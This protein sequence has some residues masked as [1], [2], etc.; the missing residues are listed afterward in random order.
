MQQQDEEPTSQNGGIFQGIELGIGAW[1]WGDRLFWGYGRGYGEQDVRAAFETCLA[2]GIRFFDTAETY[3]QGRS[4]E[5]LGKF[6]HETNADVRV[7]TKFMPYPWRLS[8]AALLRSL[9][10]S[11]SRLGLP[12][13]D[14]YQMHWPFPPVTIETWMQAMIEAYQSGLVR[15]VGVS[16]YDRGQMQRAYDSLVREGI[17]LA[18]NQ[19]EYHLLNRKVEKNGLLRQCREQG[20]VLIAYSPLA[21]GIL[22]GK[23]TPQNLPRGV[24]G[25]Q[26]NARYLTRIQPLIRLLQQIGSDL[27]GK[28]PAQVALNWIICKGALPIPGAKT[29]QQSE[30][31]AG[32]Q[33]WRLTDEQVARLDEISDRVLAS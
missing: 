29:S 20:T 18:S 16:N 22:S 27:G 5:L 17:S 15:A 7:A 31:N 10:G 28:S 6:I 1:S 8:R 9:R 33:G 25:G 21:S 26:Y 11:L 23:Y 13:V 30:Q 12:S 24:R 14:L 2:Y 32:A 4:E 3:G 19:V